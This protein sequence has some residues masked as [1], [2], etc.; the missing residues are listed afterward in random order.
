VSYILVIEM[1]MGVTGTGIACVLMNLAIAI[2]QFWYSNYRVT[3]LEGVVTW[4]NQQSFMLSGA[5]SY[6]RLG[7]PTIFTQLT[8]ALGNEINVL[9]CGVLDV[10]A[11]ASQLIM[12]NIESQGYRV[13]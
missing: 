8:D 12:Y 10:V 1:E 7:I 9:I 11:Q 5:V 3:E 2:A 4:P 13:G 6:L